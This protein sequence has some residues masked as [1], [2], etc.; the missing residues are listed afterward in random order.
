MRTLVIGDIHGYADLFKTVL[1]M[2]EST[3]EDT[4]VTL[5]DYT[6]RG[7]DSCSVIEHLIELQQRQQLIAIRGN[8]DVMMM[9]ARKDFSIYRDWLRYGGRDTLDSYAKSDDQEV[10]LDDVPASHWEFLENELVDWYETD[11]HFFVHANAY[12]DIPIHE[13]PA[14]ML[15]W[16]HLFDPQPHCSGKIMVCGHT[17]QASGRPLN[18]EHTL[19]V[20]TWVYG[21][22]WLTCLDLNSGKYWQANKKG[23]QRPGHLDTDEQLL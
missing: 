7:P 1:N 15:H 14:F 18:L 17:K 3:E 11:T 4:I 13:Q 8:H 5:G 12:P 21:E 20:D 23:E 16:E 10:T 6:D 22:G 2:A 19:C 9:D